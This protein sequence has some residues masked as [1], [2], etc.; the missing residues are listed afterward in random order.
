[1]LYVVILGEQYLIIVIL[2]PPLYGGRRIFSAERKLRNEE[3]LRS[4]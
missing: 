1:M 2:I 3:C 4:F